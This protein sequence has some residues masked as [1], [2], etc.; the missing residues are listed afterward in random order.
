MI[1]TDYVWV[2]GT[3]TVS[4]DI[5]LERM[6]R[7]DNE[8]PG[9]PLEENVRWWIEEGYVPV[10]APVYVETLEME[11]LRWKVF[12]QAMIGYDGHKLS[13]ANFNPRP[14]SDSRRG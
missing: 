2:R 11:G 10:G 12:A 8:G 9:N 4:G 13:L 3:E 7:A 14:P 1:V 6:H 5:S